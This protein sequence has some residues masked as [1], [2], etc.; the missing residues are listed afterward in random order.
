MELKPTLSPSSPLEPTLPPIKTTSFNQSSHQYNFTQPFSF[1]PV[2][3]VSSLLPYPCNFSH[4][5]H[6]YTSHWLV[7]IA[8]RMGLSEVYNNYTCKHEPQIPDAQGGTTPSSFS[9]LKTCCSILAKNEP[10]NFWDIKTELCSVDC[11]AWEKK[12]WSH[13][14][15]DVQQLL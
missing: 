2:L 4:F 8:T 5:P 1:P 13:S 9:N 12:L 14:D 6:Q 11:L 3:L 10:Q 15:F 7:L